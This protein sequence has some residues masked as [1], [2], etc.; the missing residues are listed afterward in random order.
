ML[1]QEREEDCAD[2][3]HEGHDVVPLECF[4]A[5]H[6]D[7]HG[8]EHRDGNGLLDD[9][10]LHEAEGPAVDAAPDVVGGNHEEVFDEGDT[11]AGENHEDQRPV[12]ADVH[13]LQLEVAVPGKGHEE[14][15]DDEKDDGDDSGF[16]F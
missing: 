7:S 15:A 8:G 11:P 4:S 16:H 1:L 12:G 5:E 10:Q 2:D 9:L 14:V 6:G 3:Q 13:L